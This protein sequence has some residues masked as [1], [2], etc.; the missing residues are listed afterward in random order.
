MYLNVPKFVLGMSK[1]DVAESS[2]VEKAVI[3][4]QAGTSRRP[5]GLAWMEAIF[6]FV[7]FRRP[8]GGL[9]PSPIPASF[10]KCRVSTDM[11]QRQKLR[12]ANNQIAKRDQRI[13]KLEEEL[14][15]MRKTHYFK[16]GQQGRYLSSQGGFQMAL[17]QAASLTACNSVGLAAGVDTSGKTIKSWQVLVYFVN[18]LHRV[19]AHPECERATIRIHPP[20]RPDANGHF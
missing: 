20:H 11:L 2:Q 1:L 10:T 12:R 7:R 13:A 14:A 19:R 3:A 18:V 8:L 9:A 15:S 6:R 17:R 5:G 16:R 4:I